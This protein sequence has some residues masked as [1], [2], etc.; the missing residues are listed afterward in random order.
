MSFIETFGIL[1]VSVNYIF[2]VAMYRQDKKE[3]EL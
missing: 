1:Q 2:L 3:T